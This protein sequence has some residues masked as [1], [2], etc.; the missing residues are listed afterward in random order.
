MQCFCFVSRESNSMLI[1]QNSGRDLKHCFYAQSKHKACCFGFNVL[2]P[3]F[4]SVSLQLC[5]KKKRFFNTPTRL[6]F[7]RILCIGPTDT[8]IAWCEPISGMGRTR[9]WCCSTSLSQWVLWQCTQPGSQQVWQPHA[10]SHRTVKSLLTGW[11][12]FGIL[13]SNATFFKNKFGSTCYSLRVMLESSIKLYLL[14]HFGLCDS[15][16]GRNHCFQNP[17]TH[18]CLLSAIGPRFYSCACPSGWTLASD[19]VTCARSM[20]RACVQLII[21]FCKKW[22]RTWHFNSLNCLHKM[23]KFWHFV[24]EYHNYYHCL[25]V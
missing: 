22:F 1:P 24:T 5:G 10:A 14:S 16:V 11:I 8:S 15:S 12:A 6:P 2:I 7:L 25:Y 4:S 20:Y 3:F 18:I 13:R 9:Q 19:Q 23:V 17:C 21:L